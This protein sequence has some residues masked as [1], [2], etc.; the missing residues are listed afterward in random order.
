MG[1]DFGQAKK[2]KPRKFRLHFNRVNMQ[3]GNPNIWT[4]HTSDRCYQV[5]R[6]VTYVQLETVFKPDGP[7]PRAYLSG[8]GTV[9]IDGDTAYLT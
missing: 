6:V 1:I 8:R 5:K 4:V 3:R 2:M 7:Q 9:V